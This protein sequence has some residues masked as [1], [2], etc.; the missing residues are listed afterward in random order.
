VKGWEQHGDSGPMRAV[1]VSD[2]DPERKYPLREPIRRAWLELGVQPIRDGNGGAPLGLAELVENWRNGKRQLAS[3]TYGLAGVTVLCRTVVQR[4]VI[5]EA[6]GAKTASG[7]QLVNGHII[8]ATCEVIVSC[9]AYRTPQV[10][11]LSGIGNP[12]ELARHSIPLVVENPEVGQNFHDHLALCIWWKLRH[13]ELGLAIGTPLWEN[14]AYTKGLPADWVVFQHT[15]DELLEQALHIDT[16]TVDTEDLLRPQRCHTETLVVYAPAG[17]LIAS[18]N[19][20]LDGTHITTAILGMTPTSRGSITLSSA[21]ASADPVIDPNYYAT[22]VD[23]VVLRHGI[24]QSLRLLQETTDGVSLV[25]GEVPP[26]GL[27]SLKAGSTD[28][29]IDARVRRAGNTFYHAAGSA[30]MGKVVDSQL[31]VY[32]VKGLRVVDAS[33]IPIPIAAHYQASVYAIAEKAADLILHTSRVR[34]SDVV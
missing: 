4:I 31:R 28:E 22:E 20:P 3:Q 33:V 1:S 27:P 19:L 25:E 26:E 32:G 6:S 23:R 15:P 30:S 10:L 5:D 18:V 34:D 16:N 12:Q 14:P 29:E 2:S 24:R 8:S 9:G 7:V 21:D 17:A 13:P 11:M